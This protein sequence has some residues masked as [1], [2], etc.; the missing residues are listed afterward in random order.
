MREAALKFDSIFKRGLRPYNKRTPSP[1]LYDLFNFRPLD[2]GLVPYD[3]VTIPFSEDTITDNDLDDEDFPFPQLIVSKKYIFVCCE[4]KIYTVDPDDWD[5]LTQLTTYDADNPDDTKAISAGGM[6]ELADFWDTWFLTNG[7]CTVF[8]CGKTWITSSAARKVYVS[9]V[10]AIQTTIDYKG[11]ILF[12]GFDVHNFW[13]DTAKTFLS[14]WYAKNYTTGFCAYVKI[15]GENEIAPIYQD[16]IWWSSIGGG[17]A[18]LLFFPSEVLEDGFL[19]STFGSSIPFYLDILQ[20]NEQGSAPMPAQGKVLNFRKLGDSLCVLSED[21]VSLTKAVSSPAP[22]FNIRGLEEA[23]GIN[24]RGAVAAAKDGSELVYL[25]NSG[26]LVK[27]KSSGEVIKLGYKEYLYDLIGS[28]VIISYSSE[29]FNRGYYI[30]NGDQTFIYSIEGL[31]EVGH[32]VNSAHYFKGATVGMGTELTGASN[33]IGKVGIDAN[34]FGLSGIKTLEWIRV[35]VDEYS[36]ESSPK[37]S[38]QVSIDYVHTNVSNSTWN[39]TGYR[40]VNKEGI[41]YFPVTGVKFRINIKVA[42]YANHT[43]IYAEVGIKQGDKRFTRHFSVG[44]A[45]NRAST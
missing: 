38:L 1:Q 29:P 25:D 2:I 36:E 24:N 9:A 4:T 17:D 27:I 14:T 43:I 18:L 13:S 35:E 40:N 21:G 15:D 22:T 16:F 20:R 34:D 41:V 11:R 26:T 8:A 42:N 10:T 7:V 28:D 44:E 23:G 45:V 3:P 33:I 6:W 30:S 5:S 12:G 31:F 37:P 39:S 32:V 19:T